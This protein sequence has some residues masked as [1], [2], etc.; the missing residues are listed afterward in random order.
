MD[1]FGITFNKN[2]RILSENK[3]EEMGF[4]STNRRGG[5]G[6]DDVWRFWLPQIIFT[7]SGEVRDKKTLQLLPDAKVTMKGSDGT[8]V[9]TK[10]DKNGHY[11]FNKN[12]VNKN[13]SYDLKVSKK[14]YL[15]SEEK[16]ETTVGRKSSTD[17]VLDFKIEP[18]PDE[19]VALPE[20]RFALDSSNLQEQYKDS[21]NGLI[22]TMKN[23]PQLVVELGTHT[24]YRADDEYNDTLSLERAK[25]I[26]DYLVSEGIDRER[27]KPKGYGERMPRTLKEDMTVDGYTFEEG[28]TLSENY[29]KGL[30][31]KDKR[32]A[33]H[34]LNR[35]ST[36]KVLRTDYVPDKDKVED[37]DKTGFAGIE[38]NPDE[39]KVNLLAEDN[40]YI[41][42]VIA[43]GVLLKAAYQQ[44]S[45]G[46]YLSYDKAMNFL[47]NARITKDNFE[48]GVDAI[49]DDGTIVDNS[50]LIMDNV[51]IG[52]KEMEDVEMVV[53]K[54]QEQDLV[55][56]KQGIEK[57]GE[58]T[59]N[60]EED[61][62]IFDRTVFNSQEQEEENQ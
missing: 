10:T 47:T 24:D 25:S 54:D 3:A 35:R 34:Q 4:F 13:T 1:D 19:P 61:E 17:L 42:P 9:T 6:G 18:I 48:K 39:N 7:I 23:K 52:N 44:N 21:L 20:I 29:I 15:P 50:K 45:D 11:K 40:T 53:I 56:G 14:G 26:V 51:S 22:N 37:V 62:L 12:Q 32:E 16:K 5:R 41:V 59:I 33:A 27:L 60:Q 36:F 31:S 55:I 46:I 8:S 58:F 30:R 38:L 2:D 43:N 28:T 57:F 49:K